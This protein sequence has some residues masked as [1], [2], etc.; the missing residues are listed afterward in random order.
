MAQQGKSQSRAQSPARTWPVG[1]VRRLWG[2]ATPR[3]EFLIA[4][5]LR[6]CAAAELAAA[7]LLPWLA[8]AYGVGI[9]LYF[10]A[11]REPVW[12]VA[13]LLA[14]G[15]AAAA[16]LLRRRIVAFVA[17][18]GLFAISSG[19]AIAA[20]PALSGLRRFDRWVCRATR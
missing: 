16:V 8:V 15:C 18:L 1:R 12:W 11:Q 17:A 7:H 4:A 20:N 14:A 6:Q 10:T 2:T 5:R 13:A 9:V 3:S 19:F